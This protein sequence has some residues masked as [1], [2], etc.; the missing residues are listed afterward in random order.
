MHF[1]AERGNSVSV[2][3]KEVWGALE[4]ESRRR[5]ASRVADGTVVERDVWEADFIW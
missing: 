2:V 1:L 3:R 4:L 5:L